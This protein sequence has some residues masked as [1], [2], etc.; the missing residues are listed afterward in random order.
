MATAV[1]DPG[2]SQ[3]YFELSALFLAPN[4]R[5]NILPYPRLSGS[6]RQL[7]TRKIL[8]K[9]SPCLSHPC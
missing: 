9:L 2:H 8:L 3:A 4:W 1:G 7:T 6:I 5:R